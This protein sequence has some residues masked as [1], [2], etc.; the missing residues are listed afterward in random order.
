MEEILKKIIEIDDK[1]KEI[2]F[3][4]KEKKKT[5]EEYLQSEVNTAKAILDVEYKSEMK[6]NKE[7]YDRLF[8]EKKN[9]IDVKINNKKVEID[10]FIRYNEDKIT[11]RIINKIKENI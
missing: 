6:K 4:E 5:I 10:N 2:A 3:E 1:A 11:E 9:E 7:K 8:D